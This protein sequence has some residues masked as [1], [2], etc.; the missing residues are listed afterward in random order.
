MIPLDAI[1]ELVEGHKGSRVELLQNVACGT[2]VRLLKML[3][4]SAEARKTV[5]TMDASAFLRLLSAVIEKSIAR[6]PRQRLKD[7]STVEK[8]ASLLGTSKRVLVLTGA[9]ISTSCGIPDF[10]S[11]S[12][13]YSMLGEYALEDPQ[14]LFAISYFRRNVK[15]FYHF[16]RKLWPGTH[17]P[18]TTHEFIKLI[19]SSGRLLRNYTQNIDT[20]EQ[21]AGIENIVQ[22]HGSFASATCTRCKYKCDGQSIKNDVMSGKPPMCPK[23]AVSPRPSL[24]Q[25]SSNML[26]GFNPFGSDGGNAVKVDPV[27]DRGCMKPDIVFFGEKLPNHFFDTIEQDVKRCDLVVVMGTSLKV[28]PVSRIVEMVDENVPQILINREVVGQ[29]HEFDVELLGDCDVVALAL[30]KQLG[31]KLGCDSDMNISH[32]TSEKAD[33][34]H[35]YLFQGGVDT[36]SD[37]EDSDSDDES[38]DNSTSPDCEPDSSS[39]SKIF[40]EDEDKNVPQSK[41]PLTEGGSTSATRSQ[42]KGDSR[43]SSTSFYNTNKKVRLD[44]EGSQ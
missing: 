18:A 25:P 36:D 32:R 19:G 13:I 33:K 40:A 1:R 41:R 26:F 42:E 27:Y 39:E 28:A 9:G 21:V 43:L 23:C 29:P 5:E 44:G 16:A 11:A 22:C 8:A 17:K 12:G 3:L 15:P 24:N 37:S 31:W 35:R 10:R 14:D 2:N 30:A 20:L 7:V 34:T 6:R 4:E 38:K